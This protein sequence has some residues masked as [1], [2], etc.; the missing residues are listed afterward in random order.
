M[1]EP[2][3][4]ADE[5]AD[6]TDAKIADDFA[7]LLE[8][9]ATTPIQRLK[10][11]AKPR[12]PAKDPGLLP[13]IGRSLLQGFFKGGSDEAIGGL[14]RA[15]VSPGSGAAWRMPDGSTVPLNTGWDV[16]RAGRDTER[17]TLR[18]ARENRP[19][20]AFAAEFLGDLASDAVLR[21]LGVPGVGSRAYNVGTGAL[22]GLLGS[23]AELTP[24][25]ATEGDLL[26][27]GL[28]T[29]LGG[30]AGDLGTTIGEGA[31]RVTPA[32]LRATRGWLERRGIN[33]GRRA[34]MSGSDQ[35]ARNEPVS[36]EAVREALESGAI[37][38]FGTTQGA[39]R[40][41]EALAEQRGAVYGSILEELERLGVKGPDAESLAK[42]LFDEGDEALAVAGAKEAVPHEYWSNAAA[43]LRKVQ[44]PQAL[45]ALSRL[46][47]AASGTTPPP[48]ATIS[49][50]LPLSQAEGLKRTLQKE[51]IYG[52]LEDTPVN[53]A[54]KKIAATVRRGIEERVEEAAM[55]AAP[56]SDLD[57][58][59]GAFQ[60]VKE[61]L[62]RT[63]AAE[64]AAAKGAAAA[65]KRAGLSLTDYLWGSMVGGAG[66]LGGGAGGGAL[67]AGAAL[68]GHR[69]LR[70]RGPSTGAATAYW[71]SRL[72]NAGANAAAGNPAATRM[73][74]SLAASK[75][76]GGQLAPAA[77]DNQSRVQSALSRYI[78]RLNAPQE[79]P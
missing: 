64:E 46:R 69:A 34:L 57:V 53:E 10:A 20:T 79:N 49:T 75:L 71:L 33:L 45:D 72:A 63:L 21:G 8:A 14:T 7:D 35:L 77:E 43:I 17:E 3:S 12:P 74:E 67:G 58:V 51:A 15:G 42:R 36:D 25:K 76:L 26:R 68:L 29:A 73:V 30:A 32:L 47:I 11:V 44:E 9:P 18:G 13:T 70:N 39:S 1:A 65:Q 62:A 61:R 22:S 52:K 5:F 40:R 2:Q 55:R 48:P 27:A 19:K 59:T 56:G 16:Y 38:P 60:P 6:L 50:D 41:L 37:L 4:I 78:S 23:E 28:A 66:M 24:D 54:K 31:S